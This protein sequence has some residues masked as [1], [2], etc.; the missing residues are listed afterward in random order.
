MTERTSAVIIEKPSKE[1]SDRMR[2]VRSKDTLI[3][4]TMERLLRQLYVDYEKQPKMVGRPDFI[5]RDAKIAIFCDG[6]FWHGRPSK[7]YQFKRNR[8]F[9][10]QK[11][12]A[13]RLRDRKNNQLLRSEGWKILRFWDDAILKKPRSVAKRILRLANPPPSKRI[14][15][16]ELFCGAGGLAHGFFLEGI[17]V[18]AGYDLD[19]TCKYAYERNNETTFTEKDVNELDGED[20]KK[21][22]PEGAIRVLAGCAP[23]QPFSP[24]TRGDKKENDK[25]D[26]L[27]K[28]SKLITQVQ[29]DIVTMENVPTL[30][31]FDHGKVF[32]D[33]VENLRSQHYNV[34]FKVVNCL[35]Y[36]L[37][38]HRRRL[39]LLA[40]KLG[41]IELI[42]KTHSPDLYLTVED[43][44][45]YLKPIKA[46][47]SSKKDP[48]HRARNLSPM[49]MQRI[50]ASLEGGDWRSWPEDL[51][52]E[53]HK[54]TTGKTFKNVYGRMVWSQPSPTITT[55][56]LGIGR[57]RF[58][59]PSQD[60]AISLR[61]A[62]LLQTFPY[63]Y[64][65][66]EKKETFSTE[67]VSTHIGNAVPVRLGQVIAKSIKQHVEAVN[68]A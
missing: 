7:Q 57:G 67:N 32:T 47:G 37:P 43:A 15:M 9:W 62:A 64:D 59:H 25:W 33:F 61:E 10:E 1:V 26:L 6:S 21:L 34:W 49:N 39:V 17:N 55:K 27:Y 16:V 18:V 68:F 11:I 20:V 52:L 31:S 66:I 12:R 29:P 23:C 22:Y 53:C 50:K 48:L 41:E 44:I 28:F 65:F 51:K 2:K 4:R 24:Y 56:C 8:T 14:A 35:D 30:K 36:G 38:Q 45:G 58:G 60:R 13:N 5:L 42:P 3:E 19:G 46:G 54:K 63:Y 40:S